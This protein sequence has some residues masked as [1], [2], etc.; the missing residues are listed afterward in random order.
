MDLG[1]VCTSGNESL[2]WVSRDLAALLAGAADRITIALYLYD[3]GLAPIPEDVTRLP[4][5]RIRQ[6]TEPLAGD[7]QS[8]YR[9]VVEQYERLHEYT[10]FLHGHDTS[11]HQDRS[12]AQIVAQSLQLHEQRRL[13]DYVN[14][15]RLTIASDWYEA[16]AGENSMC[17]RVARHWHRVAHCLGPAAPSRLFEIWCAQCMVHRRRLTT[18]P[19]EAWQRVLAD[20]TANATAQSDVHY[21]YEG[22]THML[23]GGEPACRPWLERMFPGGT[24][25]RDPRLPRVMNELDFHAGMD[26]LQTSESAASRKEEAR[27]E[28]WITLY[29]SVYPERD[30]RRRAELIECVQRNVECT[31]IDRIVILSEFAPP[32]ADGGMETGAGMTDDWRQVLESS[33]KVSVVQGTERPTYRAFF[34]LANSTIAACASGESKDRRHISIIANTDICFDQTARRLRLYDWQE[35]RLALALSRWAVD[36]RRNARFEFSHGSQDSWIFSGPIRHEDMVCDFHLG[37]PGCDNRIAHE[38]HQQGY[39]LK[40]VGHRLKTYHVHLVHVHNYG[41]DGPVPTPYL[42]GG[43]PLAD[44]RVLVTDPG[45]IRELEDL[46]AAEGPVQV[47]ACWF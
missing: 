1:I 38:I 35:G 24:D 30:A 41:D 18:R 46:Q 12:I 42:P 32:H 13:P 27:V 20:F 17:R 22:V 14:V 10:L 2:D 8:Y 9:Y 36:D 34:Q 40:N 26:A 11:Y 45:A 44:E 7:E 15:N 21:F 6:K 3:G 25:H 31:E 4:W 39:D 33:G 16:N 23:L 5:V 43:L 19:V 29:V 28:C 37:R 47:Q